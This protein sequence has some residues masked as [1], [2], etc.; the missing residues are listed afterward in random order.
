MNSQK[1]MV[2]RP[3]FW[4]NN[5]RNRLE[6]RVKLARKCENCGLHFTKRMQESQETFATLK[7]HGNNE[8]EGIITSVKWRTEST[9]IYL[10]VPVVWLLSLHARSWCTRW[11]ASD[12]IS[13]SNLQ[14]QRGYIKTIV[15]PW[16]K[17]T[18][19]E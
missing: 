1:S 7:T 3:W 19:R 14:K 13:R 16:I 8:T 17:S 2:Q 6:S 18:C 12:P 11:P 15:C 4:K 9:S 5:R 10:P